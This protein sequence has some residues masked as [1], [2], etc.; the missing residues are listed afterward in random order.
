MSSRLV[1]ITLF[2]F[3]FYDMRRQDLKSV[4]FIPYLMLTEIYYFSGTG[5]SYIVASTIAKKLK[6]KLIPIIPFKNNEAIKSNANIIGFV[7]PIY[8][9]KAP[10]L[11]N[12]FVKK[13]QTSDSTYFFAVCTY[14]VMPLNTMK[15]LEKTLMLN[16]RK[17]SGGFTVKMPHNGIGYSKI[18]TCS[19][20]CGNLI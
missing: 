20:S 9:F 1:D 13:L 18:R 14:G 8:D 7:F 2:F 12:D 15:K 6:A 19:I 5:N 17:L 11:I 10:E 4:L 16:D 3:S